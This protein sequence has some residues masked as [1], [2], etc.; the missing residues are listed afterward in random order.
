MGILRLSVALLALLCFVK[1][2]WAGGGSEGPVQ[3]LDGYDFTDRSYAVVGM[4]WGRERHDMQRRLG[5]FYVDDPALLEEL[6]DSWVTGGPAPF[7]A[8]G[9]HYTVYVLRWQRIVDSFSINLEV[10]AC[11]SVVT[12]GGSY[13]FDPSL[14]TGFAD[15]Y[16][17]PRIDRRQFDTLAEA[18]RALSA[19]ADNPRLLLLP[20][21]DW[22]EY[23]GEFRFMADCPGHDYDEARVKACLDRVRAEIGAAYPDERFALEET[24]GNSEHILVEMKCSEALHA[25]FR[26]YEDYWRW[27]TYEPRLTLYWKQ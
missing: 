19:L 15:R 8:C 16:R 17:K 11:G 23:D 2:A 26:L 18:R 7:Y 14:L 5:N 4:V 10:G 22:R 24:G 25:N 1:G 21:P 20:D 9:Y 3:L 6:A 13:F 12:G 27:R